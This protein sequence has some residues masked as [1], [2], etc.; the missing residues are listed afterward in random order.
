MA[1]IK[2]TIDLVMER[3]AGLVGDREDRVE[4]MRGELAAKAKGLAAR[5]LDGALRIKDIDREADRLSDGS[6]D[7]AME[8][9]RLAAGELI[10]Q[11]DLT[12]PPDQA[13][14]C[15]AALAPDRA[16]RL[17]ALLDQAVVNLGRERAGRLEA[18]RQDALKELAAWGL[19]GSAVRPKVLVG[20]D[21]APYKAD[22]KKA[23]T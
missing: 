17:H 7:R 16:A 12:D 21:Q 23:L 8:L 6:A 19:T 5:L 14:D 4:T 13:V 11:L 3:T 9:L 2:S 15:L 22:L 20:I 10:D 18:A 1:E